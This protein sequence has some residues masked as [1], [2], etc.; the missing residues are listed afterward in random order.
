MCLRIRKDITQRLIEKEKGK[1]KVYKFVHKK[2]NELYSIFYD[3]KWKL[4]ENYPDDG[5]HFPIFKSFGTVQNTGFHVFLTKEDALKS[6]DTVYF[7][8]CATL[9]EL[10]ADINDLFWAGYWENTES[11]VFSKLNL[12]GEV[13]MSIH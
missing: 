10:E 8:D 3:Y 1:F 7:I 11:A 4:G 5:Y 2:D 9:V 13:D 6:K 12:I